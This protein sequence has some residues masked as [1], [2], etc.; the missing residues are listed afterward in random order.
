ML[1]QREA[2][3]FYSRINFLVCTCVE[4]KK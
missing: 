1:P 4:N 3:L 2:F